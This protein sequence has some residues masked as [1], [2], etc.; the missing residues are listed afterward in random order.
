METLAGKLGWAAIALV[1]AV[2]LGMI[3]LERGEPINAIWL[4]AAAIATFVI[5]Y[6]FYSRFIADNALKLDPSR[7]TPAPGA[8]RAVAALPGADP[9]S[10]AV[11]W[12]RM[13]R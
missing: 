3:A 1:G 7:A 5:A 9:A 6:R 4:V 11:S 13:R 12:P 2:C 8:V 10:G